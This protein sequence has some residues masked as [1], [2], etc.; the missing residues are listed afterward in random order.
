M[1]ITWNIKRANSL[2]IFS[3]AF[4]SVDRLR[5]G[6]RETGIAD[7]LIRHQTKT[8]LNIEIS[9]PKDGGRDN[10]CVG[11]VPKGAEKFKF[12]EK[13]TL[14]IFDSTPHTR[15]YFKL[16]KTQGLPELKEYLS[17][18]L[19]ELVPN[20]ENITVNLTLYK[21]PEIPDNE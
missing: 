8:S 13:T 5:L 19:Q 10:F 16:T 12:H 6:I 14:G 21:L 7:F 9:T 4:A 18:V 3:Y 11:Y 15:S 20:M 1:N 2:C 17:L